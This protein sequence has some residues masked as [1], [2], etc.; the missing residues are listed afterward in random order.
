MENGWEKVHF[1]IYIQKRKRNKET[2]QINIKVTIDNIS[3][4]KNV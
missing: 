4:V 2:E 3:N 1:N